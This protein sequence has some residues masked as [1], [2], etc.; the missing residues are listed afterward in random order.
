MPRVRLAACLALC[1]LARGQDKPDYARDVQPI[2]EQ[3][4]GQCHISAV[5]GKLRLNSEADILR[6]GASGPAVV[7]GHSGDSLLVK[8][9][10][11]L[12]DAPR[13]PLGGQP[14]SSEKVALIRKWIDTADFSQVKAAAASTTV[15][16]EETKAE[17]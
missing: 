1:A 10:L 15:A 11:G 12:T 16:P 17:S 7:P 3:A 9:I 6:G 14:L 13:M 5:A 4:C 8:R 2:I